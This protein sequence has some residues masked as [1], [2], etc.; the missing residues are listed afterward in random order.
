M[1]EWFGPEIII[2][3]KSLTEDLTHHQMRG[4]VYILSSRYYFPMHFDG[5][6]F[7]VLDRDEEGT[8]YPTTREQF[9]ADCRKEKTGLGFVTF[10]DG[11]EHIVE[12]EIK[13]DLKG[14]GLKPILVGKGIGYE[15]AVAAVLYH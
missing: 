6:H 9:I 3:K 5:S 14:Q 12:E 13:K 15:D 1:P 2:V 4:V 11:L 8:L 10:H 7:F